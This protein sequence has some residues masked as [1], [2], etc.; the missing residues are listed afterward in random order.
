MGGGEELLISLCFT[1]AAEQS[2]APCECWLLS[3][4]VHLRLHD[5]H[6]ADKVA[7]KGQRP[8]LMY[9]SS[10]SIILCVCLISFIQLSW[11]FQNQLN[12]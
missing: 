11:P 7:R 2:A 8:I 10:K 4:Y 5:Y 6:T 12:S 3:A 9:F 1:A